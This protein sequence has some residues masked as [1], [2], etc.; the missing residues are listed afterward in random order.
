MEKHF[1]K[2]ILLSFLFALSAIALPGSAAQRPPGAVTVSA[3]LSQSSAAPAVMDITILSVYWP[4]SRVYSVKKEGSIVV[5]LLN[6][7]TYEVVPSYEY[8]LHAEAPPNGVPGNFEVK[9]YSLDFPEDP[10]PRLVGVAPRRIQFDE[11]SIQIIEVIPPRPSVNDDIV[12]RFN[13]RPAQPVV[14]E[15]GLGVARI[16]MAG[17]ALPGVRQWDLPIGK[18]PAGSIWIEVFGTLGRVRRELVVLPADPGGGENSPAIL[19][20]DFEVNV[21]WQ[22]HQGETGEGNLVQPP[23]RDSALYYFFSPENWEL[24]VKVLDGCALNGHFWVFGAASTDVGYTIRI[25]RRGSSQSFE[26]ENPVGNV[27]PA[28]T[29]I[30][31]FPCDPAQVSGEPFG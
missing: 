29:N 12:L 14:L 24:M 13:Q 27:A 21:S 11:P 5:E 16:K 2:K 3:E 17:V 15:H 30:K 19:A 6:P 25:D 1:R 10:S 18:L 9:V 8:T 23:S 20:E 28:I 22:N 7:E 4:P 31:A 26:V